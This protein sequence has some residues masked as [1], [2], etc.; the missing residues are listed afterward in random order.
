MIELVYIGQDFY[1][2]SKTMMSSIYKTT[3]ERYDYGFL[4]RD[5]EAGAE[6]HIRQA[7]GAEMRAY[8]LR[9]LD[10]EKELT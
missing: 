5:L 9:L 3:G 8:S 1:S 10:M 6:I 4:Q 7:T 2:R